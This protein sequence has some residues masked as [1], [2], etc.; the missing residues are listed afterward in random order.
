MNT[1]SLIDSL[2][3]LHA[4]YPGFFTVLTAA[5]KAAVI[6][7]MAGSLVLML[8]RRS[9]RAR[10]WAWRLA[11]VMLGLLAAWIAR[12]ESWNELG[13]NLSVVDH[14]PQRSAARVT[15]PKTTLSASDHA[16]VITDSP[17]QIGGAAISLLPPEAVKGVQTRDLLFRDKVTPE[18]VLTMTAEPQPTPAGPGP[19]AF[20]RYI[21]GR[22]INL[23]AFGIGLLAAWKLARAMIGRCWLRKHSHT[24]GP[25]VMKWCPAGLRCRVSTRIAAPLITGAFRPVVWL[26]A[27]AESWSDLKLRAAFQHELAHHLR[28]DVGWQSLGTWVACIWWWLPFGWLALARMKAEA[29]QAADDVTVTRSLS[30]S[31]Y[32]EAL[33][34]IAR[35]AAGGSPALRVG[36]A[37][38][39]YSD[40]EMRVRALLRDNPWRDRL[41]SVA[42]TA[43]AAMVIVASCLVLT[44]C[45]RQAPQ[46]VSMAK[47]VA[48]G[49][50]VSGTPS[51]SVV[52]DYL[53]DF[54][55][56]IIETVESKVLYRRALERVRALNPG[57]KECDV[58]LKVTQSKGSG[59]FTVTATGGEP[60]FTRVFLDALLD[61]FRAFREA[62][63]EQ[64]R[65]KALTSLAE[66]VV[67]REAAV[68]K[69]TEAV[70][71][72]QKNNNMVV[73]ASLQNQAAEML[74]QITLERNRMMLELSEINIS[75]GEVDAAIGSKRVYDARQKSEAGQAPAVEGLTRDELDY[76]NTRSDLTVSQVELETLLESNKPD[77]QKVLDA[78]ERLT[79]L[80]KL[81]AV[82]ATQVADTYKKRKADLER[83]LAVLDRRAEEFT[84][85]AA[86]SGVKMAEH[87]RL[88]KDLEDSEKAY[89][90]LFE[91]VRKFQVSEETGSDY[92]SVM[93]RASASLEVMQPW[94]RL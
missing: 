65:N 43:M 78:Q 18:R 47:L 33:V 52:Q 17:Q 58:N 86:E 76:L 66:D 42:G 70:Q 80:K 12:P 31:D 88:T 59:I 1:G 83:R 44:G 5:L 7:V 10:C 34:Q 64:Q 29:E 71:A 74:K 13:L 49:R 27:D 9:S 25:A 2:L 94:W 68:K 40:L 11:L 36:V 22:M 55:G 75:S 79:R 26:P 35:G 57:L 90:D 20:A 39:G 8:G 30:V 28:H 14:S 24:A 87:A 51:P 85:S 89:K 54:Y 60:K 45:K 62:V 61:E 72:F 63:R 92:I 50:L 32:A 82:Y 93:E 56:T 73:L 41:G 37:M 4:R 16:P 67:K 21:D 19:K 81:L 38:S 48:G 91:L 53:A 3:S 6:V 46:Y 84:Q 15:A 77:S 69:K 23:W